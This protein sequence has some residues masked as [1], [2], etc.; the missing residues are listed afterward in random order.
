LHSVENGVVLPPR[1]DILCTVGNC[2]DRSPH[3]G[4]SWAAQEC[5]SGGSDVDWGLLLALLALLLHESDEPPDW[6]RVGDQGVVC[7]EAAVG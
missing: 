4:S 2:G 3:H 6:A 1:C 5:Y 7:H